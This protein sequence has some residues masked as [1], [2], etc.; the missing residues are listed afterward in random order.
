MKI[1]TGYAYHLRD[2]LRISPD[3]SQGRVCGSESRKIISALA[4]TP[5]REF[6]E[7]EGGRGVKA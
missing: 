2:E 1:G 4:V 7:Y 6:A 3:I 5:G